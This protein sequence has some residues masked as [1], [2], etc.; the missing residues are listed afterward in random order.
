MDGNF[1]SLPDT[2][3]LD[4]FVT[5]RHKPPCLSDGPTGVTTANQEGI[6]MSNMA[7]VTAEQAL[8]SLKLGLALS[9][10][11]FLWGPPGVGKSGLA[12]QF[13]KAVNGHL[14]D[15]RLGQYDSV[16][17]RGLPDVDTHHG[18]TV[19]RVPGTLPFEGT[20]FA[21]ISSDEP[22]ILFLDEA[23]QASPAVQGVAFQLVLERR[24]GE[25]RLLPNVYVMAASNRETDKAGVAR[26][27]TPLAD[28]FTHLEMLPALKPWVSWARAAGVPEP[29]VNYVRFR[30]DNL[31]TFEQAQKT[32]AKAFATPRTWERVGEVLRLF[33]D[34]AGKY[35]GLDRARANIDGLV[36]P[37]IGAEL[38]GFIEVWQDMPDIDRIIREPGGAPVPDAPD[39]LFAVVSALANRA[40]KDTLP[41]IL[42][43]GERLPSEMMVTMV[44]DI[45]ER[46]SELAG[47]PQMAPFYSKY[48][49]LMF[50]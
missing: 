1:T 23:M 3:K 14:I 21:D 44:V 42:E 38:M 25:H 43:Y 8:D 5:S 36:G 32:N 29:V 48:S 30:P 39:M 17:M 49:H 11:V 18:T 2:R 37:G 4:L 10:P 19:W 20:E 22:I 31:D 13:A 50:G 47:H 40:D 9:H 33:E 26:M 28:R 34:E 27:Q 45:V 16:D 7:T 46:K 6:H 24:V 15:L 41:S 12:R 35:P